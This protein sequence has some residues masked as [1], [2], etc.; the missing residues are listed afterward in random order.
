M[1]KSAKQICKMKAYL[2]IN[3]KTESEVKHNLE[4]PDSHTNTTIQMQEIIL[5]ILFIPVVKT[6]LYCDDHLEK[7]EKWPFFCLL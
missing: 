5:V 7:N 6:V 3:I 4:N 2:G 1:G